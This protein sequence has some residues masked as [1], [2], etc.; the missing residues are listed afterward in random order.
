MGFHPVA[1]SQYN[2][3]QYNTVHYEIA[4]SLTTLK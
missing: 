2:T 3:I 1:V 4:A